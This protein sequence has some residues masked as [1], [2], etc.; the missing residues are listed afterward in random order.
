[1]C[2]WRSYLKYVFIL[3]ICIHL[4]ISDKVTT[5]KSRETISDDFGN[6]LETLGSMVYKSKKGAKVEDTRSRRN[7]YSFTST[8]PS[9]TLWRSENDNHRDAFRDMLMLKLVSYYENKYKV[10]H[11]ELMLGTP[12]VPTLEDTTKKFRLSN[13]IKNTERW[14]IDDN[15]LYQNYGR[16]DAVA[17]VVV[18]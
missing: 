15:Q 12:S 14:N 5:D 17:E 6:F 3:K 9:R 18:I 1:M 11:A 16:N 4:S 10:S 13:I 8:T 7:E 2:E